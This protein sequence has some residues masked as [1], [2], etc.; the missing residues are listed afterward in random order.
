MHVIRLEGR[1]LPE[2]LKVSIPIKH[3][4]RYSEPYGFEATFEIKIEF[5]K[6][7]LVC[8]IKNEIDDYYEIC[9]IRAYEIVSTLIDVFAFSK[10]WA[11]SLIFDTVVQDEKT[12]QINFGESSV[13][14]RCTAFE[15]SGNFQRI[16]EIVMDDLNLRLAFRDLISSLNTFNYSAIA[17]ARSVEAIRLVMAPSIKSES[18]AWDILRSKLRIERGY[19]QF[20]T[21][22][23]RK[24]RHGNRG[25]TDGET[26]LEVT[27]RAWAVMNRYLEFML[28]GGEDILP[29]NKFPLLKSN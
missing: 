13:R 22:A 20:V 25:E 6:I 19:L 29:E 11:L 27:H 14:Q 16:T 5:G 23:S 24:P 10:G 17:A 26:Q 28:R 15:N 9:V 18:K 21:D 7:H 4:I 8:N 1:V 12:K 3:S 2:L